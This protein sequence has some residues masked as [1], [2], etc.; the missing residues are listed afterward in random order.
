MRQVVAEGADLAGYSV[1]VFDTGR[2]ELRKRD[3][4]VQTGTTFL[5]DTSA[6]HTLQ[7][8]A[9]ENVITATLDGQVLA[10]Y[11]D[12]SSTP[13]MSGRISIVSGYY[14]TWFDNLAVTPIDGLSWHAVKIDDAD[15]RISYPNGFSFTQAGFAHFNRT[16]H[17]LSTGRSF[18][19]D[20][21]GT[22]FN[23]IGATAASALSI[24]IDGEPARTANVGATGNRQTS[25]WLRGLTDGPHTVTVRTTSGTFTLDGV[26]VL[27]GGGGTGAVDPAIRPVSVTQTLPRLTTAPAVVPALPA[28]LAATSETGAAIDAP[29]TWQANPAQFANPYDMVKVD[30]T[31]VNNPSL[32][33]SAYVE[34]VPPGTRYFVDANAPADGVAFPAIDAAAGDT[35]INTTP[36]AAY[37][38]AAGWGR[39]GTYTGKGRL[40]Q[41]PYDKS[42]ETGWYTSGPST[43][44]AYRFTLPAGEYEIASGHTEWW[45]PGSNRSRRVTTTIGYADAAGLPVSQTIGTH[46]F[47]NGSLGTTSVLRGTFTL[48]QPTTVTFSVAGTGGTEAPALS[49]IGINDKRVVVDKSALSALLTEASEAPRRAYT[50]DSWQAMRTVGISSKVVYDDVLATQEQVDAAASALQAAIDALIEV[51]YIPAADYRIAV[52]VGAQA[53]EL[54][55]T[56]ELS[57]ISGVKQDVAVT[58]TG[59]PTAATPFAVETLPGSADGVAVTLAVE[60][61]P[62]GTVYFV[63]AASL[64]GGGTSPSFDAVATLRGDLLRNDAPDGAFTDAAGWGLVNPVDTG[65]GFVGA[66]GR[67]SGT[68]D[69]QRTTG[70]WASSG[71]SIDYR[72]TLPAGSYELTS[73]YQEWWGVTRQVVP[74]VTVGDEVISGTPV[75]LSSSSTSGTSTIAFSLEE[76]TTV[77]FRAARGTGTADPVLSWLSVVDTTRAGAP[78][79]PAAAKASDTSITVTWDAS[80]PQGS[81]FEGYLVYAAGTDTV[82]GSTTSTSLTVT[83]L[84]LGSTHAYEIVGV[85]EHG[86]S[87]RSAA[88]ASVTLPEVPSNDGAT[89][90]PGKGVLSSNDGWDTGLKDGTFQLTMD[91]WSGENGSLFKLY[92]DGVLVSSTTLTMASP[93]AQKAVVEIAGL[94]NG[95]YQFTGALVNSKG[96]T[97]TKALTVKVTD[98]SPGKPVLSADNWD[99]DGSYTVT[100]DLWWGTNASSYRFLEGGVE[101]AAGSLVVGT[102]AAQKATLPVTGKAKGTY[103]YTV[104]FINAA[105]V[106]VSAP[107]SVTVTK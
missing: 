11:A 59:T 12:T 72:L 78:G 90:A 63:D 29:I 45:N 41:T 20:M 79:N 57:T 10:T 99:G 56:V 6:W 106:T 98:A 82:V 96:T 18:T 67:V 88:T 13:I 95:T 81:A 85:N 66:K 2:W 42:K 102:P 71:G 14:N 69:K 84:A 55:E 94:K 97:A 34:V 28:T 36:D 73:G 9:R 83:G 51:A 44:I 77:L 53:I 22:G 87:P 38:S 49:W 47:V 61:V 105:G 32:A 62:V 16:Q 100:A 15:S 33:V 75:N 19:F 3:T 54:P 8:E 80:E 58:W 43:P 39:V 52:E 23:L 24:T 31:F 1:R 5:F 86:E 101:V 25:Y 4:V 26:D 65:A 40:N 76:E 46:T 70:W 64:V 17:V 91:L 30:G 35:L 60:V 27:I 48:T 93:S 21:N 92:Q 50:A 104:E 68:Y 107:L 74:S 7:L 37:T 103:V 89:K